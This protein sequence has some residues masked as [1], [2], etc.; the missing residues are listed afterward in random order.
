MSVADNRCLSLSA[1]DVYKQ[2][3]FSFQKRMTISRRSLEDDTDKHPIAACLQPYH[4]QQLVHR[5]KLIS[6]DH[7][8]HLSEA[9]LITSLSLSN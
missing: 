6:H 3:I 7:L 5:Q 9:V 2:L 4:C 1:A 8:T